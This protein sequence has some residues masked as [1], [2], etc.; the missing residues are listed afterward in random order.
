MSGFKTTPSI[1]CFSLKGIRNFH[2]KVERLD[3]LFNVQTEIRTA[4]RLKS[5][6]LCCT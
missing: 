4:F 1:S 2:E 3:V 6:R 5:H